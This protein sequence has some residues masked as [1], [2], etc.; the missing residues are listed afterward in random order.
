[1]TNFKIRTEAPCMSQPK[2]IQNLCRK[3]SSICVCACVRAR[4]CVCACVCV[5]VCMY[6]RPHEWHVRLPVVSGL[7][8][9]SLGQY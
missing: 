2:P 1:M 3:R 8:T 7:A 9:R 6:A 4:A 5:C